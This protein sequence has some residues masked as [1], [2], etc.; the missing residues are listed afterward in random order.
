MS[1][2]PALIPTGSAGTV[3]GQR[4]KEPTSQQIEDAA[5]L[6]FLAA[7][8]KALRNLEHIWD[9]QLELEVTYTV[10]NQR[11]YRV[12]ASTRAGESITGTAGH[13]VHPAN[14]TPETAAWG[15]AREARNAAAK[16]RQKE[17]INI[18]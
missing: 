7:T 10:H 11:S 12:H 8:K 4:Y 1:A 9:V 6:M 5:A 16:R 3:G 15:I 2:Q 17:I 14:G 18:V 13:Y